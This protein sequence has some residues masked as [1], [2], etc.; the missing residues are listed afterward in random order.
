MLWTDVMRWPSHRLASALI[1]AALQRHSGHHRFRNRIHHRLGGMWL[2][3]LLDAPSIYLTY[4]A[5]VSAEEDAVYLN[6]TA[7]L[8]V[9]CQLDWSR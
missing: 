1:V 6:S 3:S 8:S 4:S 9:I 5:W 2:L 7:D